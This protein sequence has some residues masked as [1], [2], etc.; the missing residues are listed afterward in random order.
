MTA[1][2]CDSSQETSVLPSMS[3]CSFS[4]GYQPFGVNARLLRSFSPSARIKPAPFLGA[5]WPHHRHR[6]QVVGAGAAA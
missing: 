2:F 6:E 3:E 5:R 1:V 4:I